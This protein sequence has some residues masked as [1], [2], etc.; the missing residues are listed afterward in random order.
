MLVAGQYTSQRSGGW[1]GT[2]EWGTE[3]KEHSEEKDQAER[4]G[5]FKD[6]VGKYKGG[7]T[8]QKQR[9]LT[10]LDTEHMVGKGAEYKKDEGEKIHM[11][12]RKKSTASADCN[13]VHQQSS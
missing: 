1:V 3:K 5:G 10:V 13:S 11:T 9:I 7:R 2:E 8:R 6:G 12:A 4:K